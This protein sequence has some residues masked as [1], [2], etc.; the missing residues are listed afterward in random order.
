MPDSQP[1]RGWAGIHCEELP[2]AWLDWSG[3]RVASVELG[4]VGDY[5]EPRRRVRLRAST[6]T[7][8]AGALDRTPGRARGGDRGDAAA[9]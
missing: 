5:D 7:N 9:A 2:L 8:A 6:T 3:A 1:A 4:R